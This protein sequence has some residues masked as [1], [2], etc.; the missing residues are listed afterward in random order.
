MNYET[1]IDAF[2]RATDE[3]PVE[4]LTKTRGEAVAEAPAA[5]PRMLNTEQAAAYVGLAKN[6]LEKARTCGDGPFFVKFSS[7]AVRYIVDDLDAWI[8]KHRAASTSEL[9]ERAR[10]RLTPGDYRPAR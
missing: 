2:T 9:D 6:T 5:G 4:A 3:G 7:R 8:A 10:S 1:T